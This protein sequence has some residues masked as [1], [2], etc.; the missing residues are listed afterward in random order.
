MK[1]HYLEIVTDEVDAVCEAY[2]A[3]QGLRFG[4]PEASLGNA[5]TAR[6]PAGGF[7][8]IRA[9]LQAE[10]DPAVRPYWL[11]DDIDAA[12][13]AAVA[14]GCV[15]AIPPTEIPGRGLFAIYWQGGNH[16]GLWQL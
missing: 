12:V 8:G 5:R 10:E 2:A 13:D 1:I 11:V 14:A 7:V 16:H 15:L 6:L 9:R 3:A 4:P